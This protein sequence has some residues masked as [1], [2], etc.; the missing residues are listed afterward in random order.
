MLI[1]RRLRFDRFT[2]RRG[3]HRFDPP[4]KLYPITQIHSV[5]RFTVA[6]PPWGCGD[7]VCR[8]RIVGLRRP[9]RAL[10]GS[11]LRARTVIARK[12]RR[13]LWRRSFPPGLATG[14]WLRM[15]RRWF[16][17]LQLRRNGADRACC[18]LMR[19]VVS[20]SGPV[21]AAGAIGR[22]QRCH[23]IPPEGLRHICD[24]RSGRR[25]VR[26]NAGIGNARWLQQG[27]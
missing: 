17:H 1:D 5:R 3:L 24:D 10:A 21:S 25:F 12:A 9:M 20:S 14:L 19:P 22:R 11:R 8:T 27:V 2:H 15:L 13:P 4:P 6:L 23:V 7:D 16:G 18:R 26:G